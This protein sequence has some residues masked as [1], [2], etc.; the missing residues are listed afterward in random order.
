MPVIHGSGGGRSIHFLFFADDLSADDAHLGST[1]TKHAVTVLRLQPGDLLQLTDGR[2]CRA[3]GRYETVNGREMRLSIVE[4]TIRCRQHPRIHLFIGLPDRDAFETVLLDATALGVSRIIPIA[5]EQCQKRW[6]KEWDN[7]LPRFR[8]KMIVALKQSV[9]CF[10]PEISVPCGTAEAIAGAEGFVML[11]DPAG[12]PVN[13]LLP[14]N[15]AMPVSCFIGPP[16]GFS[17]KERRLFDRESSCRVRI[18]PAR[19]RTELAATA[20][21]AQVIGRLL[22]RGE[23]RNPIGDE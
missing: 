11:A 2:G 20:L 6:W 8:Q 13:T 1:E 23:E 22:E 21:C 16:G 19:L 7:H 4:R 17:E 9:S 14:F 5:A 10:L 18:A 12:K 3:V 15:P